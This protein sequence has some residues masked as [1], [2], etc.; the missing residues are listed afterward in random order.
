MLSHLAEEF[1]RCL[2]VVVIV[3]TQ[4]AKV[5]RFIDSGEL[6]EALPSSSNPRNEFHIELD[7]T[8]WNLQ[9]GIGWP[10]TRTILFPGYLSDVVAVKEFQDGRR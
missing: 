4:D 10:G 8:A 1:D 2:R 5:R 7:R 6:I 3:D 9:R